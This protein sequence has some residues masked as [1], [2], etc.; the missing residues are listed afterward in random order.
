MNPSDT[1]VPETPADK[2][3]RYSACGIIELDASLRVV[4]INAPLLD[5]LNI[6]AKDCVGPDGAGVSF[7][8]LARIND[9]ECVQRLRKF[10][11]SALAGIPPAALHIRLWGKG[12]S[13][14]T[15][16]LLAG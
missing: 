15:A 7:V 6:E 16:R 9:E 11:A 10:V 12:R 4:A 3:A 1:L 2:L 14:I 5:W 13:F 8:E